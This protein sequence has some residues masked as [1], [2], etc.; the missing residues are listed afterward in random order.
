[1]LAWDQGTHC[2][3]FILAKRGA[4]HI[5]IVSPKK[6]KWAKDGLGASKG[7]DKNRVLS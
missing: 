1:M 5:S 7:A 6:E 2:V 3:H 4:A